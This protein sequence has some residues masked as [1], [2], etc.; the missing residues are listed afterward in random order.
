MR[1]TASTA[2]ARGHAAPATAAWRARGARVG[3]KTLARRATLERCRCLLQ[4]RR[5]ARQPACDLPAGGSS[6]TSR[7]DRGCEA[8]QPPRAPDDLHRRA[9]P[10]PRGRALLVD[11]VPVHGLRVDGTSL[12]AIHAALRRARP[13][14]TVSALCTRYGIR[15]F[16]RFANR[17]RRLFGMLPSQMLQRHRAHARNAGSGLPGASALHARARFGREASTSAPT[18][19]RSFP[20]RAG[21][22]ERIRIVQPGNHAGASHR[23]L[24]VA[25]KSGSRISTNAWLIPLAARRTA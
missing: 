11:R 24:T 12:H 13:D 15:D 8:D 14:D 17:Y 1:T 22:L 5:V 4:P 10:S 9:R 18:A 25:G 7:D 20:Y 6:R 2:E 16:G 23:H 19:R 21:H 3:S